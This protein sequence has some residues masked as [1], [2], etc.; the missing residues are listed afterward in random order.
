MSLISDISMSI[1]GFVAG[2]DADLDDPLGQGGERLHEWILG[3]ASWRDPHGLEGGEATPDDDIVREGRS[4]TGAVMMG[5]RM[6]SGGGG[7]CISGAPLCPGAA[8]ACR[9]GP[10]P[11]GA[12]GGTPRRSRRRCSCSPTTPV[13]P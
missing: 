8:P 4:R 9:I 2:P 12:G 5:G 11:P 7:A 1:D 6:D 13:S 10:P 3:L